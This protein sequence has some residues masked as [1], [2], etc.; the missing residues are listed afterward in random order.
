MTPGAWKSSRPRNS[1]NGSISYAWPFGLTTG[2]A[3]RWSGHSYDNAANTTRLDDYTLTNLRL[4]VQASDNNW[5]AHFFVNN[6]FNELAVVSSS[7]S[8]N[9]GGKTVVF[10]A[11]PRTYGINLTKKF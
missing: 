8:S 5:G 4:G 9:T 6:L 11:P 1:A 3:L 7:S 10:T 2:A